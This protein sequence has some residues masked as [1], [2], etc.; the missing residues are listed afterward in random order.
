MLLLIRDVF[1]MALRYA[2]DA[3]ACCLLPCAAFFA[4]Y[5]AVVA[6][7]R[8][9]GTCLLRVADV[10]ADLPYAARVLRAL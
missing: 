7:L 8:R 2:F 10:A 1:Q 9:Y 4:T 5:A 6:T 3:A